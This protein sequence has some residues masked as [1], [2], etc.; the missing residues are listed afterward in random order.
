MATSTATLPGST[1]PVE[2]II[3]IRRRQPE[4]QDPAGYDVYGLEEVAKA[5]GE[6]GQQQTGYRLLHEQLTSVP[7]T[8]IDELLVSEIPAY[9]R[10]ER[11]DRQV[12]VVVSTKS[13]TGRASDFERNVLHKI[14]HELGLRETDDS[15]HGSETASEE[16]KTSYYHVENTSGPQSI[17]A[18]G[19]SLGSSGKHTIVLLS[20]DGGVVELLN[21]IDTRQEADHEAGGSQPE[22]RQPLIAVL[23]LGTGNAL[24][25][26]L[27][28]QT[29]SGTPAVSPLVQGLRTL[30]R[31]KDAPLPCFRAE[32]SQ[33][34]H[35]VH[36][37]DRGELVSK[38][39]G[40]IVASYGFHSQLV[41]ESDTEEYRKHGDKRFQMVA[42]E[43][44]KE[45]H[46]YQATVELLSSTSSDGRP[47]SATK[48][49]RDRH[50]Y[51][52]A[53]MVSNLERTFTISPH[54]KPLDNTLRLVHFGI[55]NGPEQ[56][57]RIMDV[58]MKAY[59]DGKHI[60]MRW[61]D[62]DEA[63]EGGDGGSGQEYAVG[64]DEVPTAV[65]ITTHES[66][67]RWRKVCIDGTIVEIP[68]GGSMTVSRE[69]AGRLRILVDPAALE[70]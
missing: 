22:P 49:D 37:S 47:G 21:A 36:G 40:A 24:F 58:M 52:L 38:L 33:G 63:A 39:Y 60:G 41:W 70:E 61:T 29:V 20:G 45:A 64:Y 10:S 48:I 30:L 28:K 11:R 46:G 54:S 1:I 18:F 8:W 6:A 13:G 16:S 9:L 23:P 50:A 35:L 5:A 59:D 44:L 14:F 32:F 57:K 62:A 43:L 42:G 68:E 27:H 31:G 26:S 69:T 51:I 4:Q 65:K 67:D 12:H 66:D 19:S 55:G 25:N 53:T 2:S 15:G 3:Y 56:G 17:G 7:Q 34:S